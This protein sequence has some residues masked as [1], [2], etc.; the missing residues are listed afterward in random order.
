[1][2]GQVVFQRSLS[3]ADASLTVKTLLDFDTFVYIIV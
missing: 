1:M 3:E 2:E